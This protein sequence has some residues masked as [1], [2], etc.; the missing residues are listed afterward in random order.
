MKSSETKQGPTPMSTIER[1]KSP[2]NEGEYIG[3][4][5]ELIVEVADTSRKIDL[6]PKFEDYRR[7]G[8]LEY[9]VVALEPDEVSW[10]VRREDRLEPMPP[11]PDGVF[12][13]QVFPGLWLDP[14]ALFAEDF[15]RLIATLD[16][17]LATPEHAD[18]VARLAAYGGGEV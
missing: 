7:A 18:F 9:V 14:D 12:R 1:P 8:V 2:P 11:G 4:A 15:D 6:G 16:Q 3:G 13:S 10:F 5:P 17:G